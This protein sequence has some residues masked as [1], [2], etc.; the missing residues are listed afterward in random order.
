MSSSPPCV[1]IYSLPALHVIY[2]RS[3]YNKNCS[4]IGHFLCGLQLQW[5]AMAPDKHLSFSATILCACVYCNPLHTSLFGAKLYTTIE[6]RLPS[7]SIHAKRR[8]YRLRCIVLGH[9]KL[10]PGFWSVS[11]RMTKRAAVVRIMSLYWR[12][13]A[14]T[15]LS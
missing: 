10:H 5:R 1:C 3:A 6:T 4:T 11:F 14:I 15:G 9:S 12:D 13:F 2:G 7:D 8:P